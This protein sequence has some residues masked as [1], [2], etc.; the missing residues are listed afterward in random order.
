MK[1]TM[2]FAII[3][4]TAIVLMTAFNI[5]LGPAADV[6][7]ISAENAPNALYVCPAA[8]DLWD[9]LATGFAVLKRPLI[10]GF[11]FAVIVLLFTWGW[12]LYQN[13]LKD[14]FVRDAFKT[15][16]AFT[17]LLFW[18]VVIVSLL[19]ATPNYF[20]TVHLTGASGNWVL[21]DNNSP[22]AQPVRASAVHR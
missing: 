2:M 9:K 13:L 7:A 19:L 17:K 22:G 21:C 14:K 12:A 18:G 10:I 3:M 11:F 16:W 5:H 6:V 15:P 4:L 8:S 20:R 1:P